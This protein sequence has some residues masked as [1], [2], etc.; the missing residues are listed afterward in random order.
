MLCS[1]CSLLVLENPK[2]PDW[3]GLERSSKLLSFLPWAGAP[4]SSP[5]CSKASAASSWCC[6]GFVLLLPFSLI[7][8]RWDLPILELRFSWLAMGLELLKRRG[9]SHV[10][11]AVTSILELPGWGDPGVVWIWVHFL[12]SLWWLG[13]SCPFE[14]RSLYFLAWSTSHC[15]H[16]PHLPPV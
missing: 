11:V 3:F 10:G 14:T 6:E 5:G 16:L 9:V 2:I 8:Q 13:V 4:S 15:H 7:C 12:S 1:L